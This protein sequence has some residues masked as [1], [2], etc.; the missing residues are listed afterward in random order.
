MNNYQLI[1]SV[2]EDTAKISDIISINRHGDNRWSLHYYDDFTID[3]HHCSDDCKIIFL[4]EI[5]LETQK[6]QLE[7]YKNLLIY[8]CLWKETGGIRMA[9]S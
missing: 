1:D 3:I 7:L 4:S 9:L 2:I 6:N 5:N 8:N